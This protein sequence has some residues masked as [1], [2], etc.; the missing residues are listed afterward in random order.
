MK[1]AKATHSRPAPKILWLP[2]ETPA[3]VYLRPLSDDEEI[4]ACGRKLLA[5][6]PPEGIT[7]TDVHKA[8]P[9]GLTRKA[10]KAALEHLIDVAAVVGND[11]ERG[12]NRQIVTVYRVAGGQA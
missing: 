8:P 1:H 12:R 11:E 2:V 6:V 10:A 5:A 9:A 4:R 7:F 3:G